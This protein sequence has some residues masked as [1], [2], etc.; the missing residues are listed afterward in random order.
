MYYFYSFAVN[1]DI[2]FFFCAVVEK[3]FFVDFD[4]FNFYSENCHV[5]YCDNHNS[6]IYCSNSFVIC[7]FDIVYSCCL[8]SFYFY[9]KRSF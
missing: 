7:H 5:I 6:L 9:F 2:V 3:N 8:I 1:F 4:N